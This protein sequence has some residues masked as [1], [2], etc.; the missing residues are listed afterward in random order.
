MPAGST[1]SMST[2][3]IN[4]PSR[5]CGASASTA[6]GSGVRPMGPSRP[7]H[8]LEVVEVDAHVGAVHGGEVAV[9]VVAKSE[10][11]AMHFD[12]APSE[13]RQADAGS[14]ARQRGGG[15]VPVVAGVPG[16]LE[17]VDALGEVSDQ[18]VGVAVGSGVDVVVAPLEAR[19]LRA[20]FEHVDVAVGVAGEVGEDVSDA[21]SRQSA[22]PGRVEVVEVAEGGEQVAVGGAASAGVADDGGGDGHRCSRRGMTTTVPSGSRWTVTRTP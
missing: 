20:S 7:P 8:H 15:E 17:P 3:P 6:A 5:R 22:R 2:R 12:F 13:Q 18:R 16:G 14:G 11:D 19:I 21:P 9:V 1:P 4:Q 10:V